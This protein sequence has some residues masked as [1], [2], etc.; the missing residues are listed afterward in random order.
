M[1]MTVFNCFISLLFISVAHIIITFMDIESNNIII[2]M[3]HHKSSSCVLLSTYK[4][5]VTAFLASLQ[6]EPDSDQYAKPVC[7]FAVALWS[8]I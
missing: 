4:C 3:S 8:L 5:K 2:K 6:R 7:G 1:G